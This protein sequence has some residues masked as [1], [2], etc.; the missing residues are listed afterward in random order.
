MLCVNVLDGFGAGCEGEMAYSTNSANNYNAAGATT[1]AGSFSL[2]A[3]RLLICAVGADNSGTNGASSFTSVTFSGSVSPSPADIQQHRTQDPGAANAGVTLAICTARVTASG[4]ITITAN[5]S[6]ATPGRVL[7]PVEAWDTN[8]APVEVVSSTS[9]AGN[10]TT[11]SVAAILK[12]GDIMVSFIAQ[13][14]RTAP[15]VDAAYYQE[16]RTGAIAD[17]GTAGTSIAL[18]TQT[19]RVFEDTNTAYSPVLTAARDYVIGCIVLRAAI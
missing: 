19:G 3:G 8:G 9:N 12:A 13:E 15:G 14:A 4:S 18:H 10:G 11:P 2:T 7:I 5:F 16:A 1:L 6:P 17:S